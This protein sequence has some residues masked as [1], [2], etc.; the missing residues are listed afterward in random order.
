MAHTQK[1]AALGAIACA[2]TVTEPAA[3]VENAGQ[4]NWVTMSQARCVQRAQEVLNAASASFALGYSVNGNYDGWLVVGSN[5]NLRAEIACI[6]DDDT[7]SNIV[8]ANASRV[9]VAINVHTSLSDV[10]WQVRDFLRECFY[11]NACERPTG[12]ATT[13]SG[14]GDTAAKR[15]A[16]TLP[17]DTPYDQL[18]P[19]GDSNVS[20]G[21]QHTY[22][23]QRDRAIGGHNIEALGPIPLTECQD[24]CS[25]QDRCLS[26]EIARSTGDCR[27]Q[28]TATGLVSANGFNTYIKGEPIPCDNNRSRVRPRG[29]QLARLPPASTSAFRFPLPIQP[30]DSMAEWR[31]SDARYDAKP[32]QITATPAS[33]GQTSYF[34]APDS[35]KGDWR[36]FTSLHFEKMSGGGSYAAPDAYGAYG[37][38]VIISGAKTA[39]MDIGPRHDGKWASFTVPLQEGRWGLAG[40][41]RSLEDVLANVTDFRIRAEYG[42]GDDYSGLRSVRLQ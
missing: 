27:L 29:D 4:W 14:G 5:S 34:F 41:A 38:V 8:S 18:P 30:S 21:R 6:A 16:P 1:V 39:R 2:V 3:Q 25:A 40:G 36:G 32:A 26:I 15:R 33:D 9:L 20:C 35:F 17:P 7:T 37:D 24:A 22:S 19:P 12:N 31:V 11:N 42:V 10:S 28:D 13:G 23:L